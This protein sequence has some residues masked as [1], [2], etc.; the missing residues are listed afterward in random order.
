MWI[1]VVN[2]LLIRRIDYEERIFRV[3]D[4]YE[5]FWRACA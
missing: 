3:A 1:S 4:M 2:G 5:E